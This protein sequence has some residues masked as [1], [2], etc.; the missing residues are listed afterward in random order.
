MAMKT[1]VKGSKWVD[2]MCRLIELNDSERNKVNTIKQFKGCSFYKATL[3]YNSMTAEQK[4]DIKK[5]L[6]E[7]A[8]SLSAKEI[9]LNHMIAQEV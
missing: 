1:R 9:I 4:A 2:R 5:A 6:S 7:S 3:I 8:N